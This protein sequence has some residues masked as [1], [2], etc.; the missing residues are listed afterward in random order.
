MAGEE[1]LLAET[2]ETVASPPAGNHS[3]KCPSGPVTLLSHLAFLRKLKILIRDGADLS[4]GRPKTSINLSHNP[5]LVLVMAMIHPGCR[6]RDKEPALSF[7]DEMSL[8][9]NI[10]DPNGA[11]R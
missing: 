2:T 4:K 9:I 11:V 10:S 3:L 5:T 7:P 6:L 1:I 8:Q